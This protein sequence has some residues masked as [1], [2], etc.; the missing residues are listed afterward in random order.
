MTPDPPAGHLTCLEIAVENSDIAK[1]V[2]AL[3]WAYCWAIARQIIGHDPSVEEVADWW[4]DSHR[5]TYRNQA[6]FRAAFPGLQ[7]PA[8]IFET[9]ESIHVLDRAV[10]GL[11][12]AD[13]EKNW[14]KTSVE[15]GVVKLGLL[16]APDH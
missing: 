7:S 11:T 5:T 8:P 10:R 16:A 3:T 1:A 2:K 9:P 15:E 4:G 6:A 13:V 12:R 14:K